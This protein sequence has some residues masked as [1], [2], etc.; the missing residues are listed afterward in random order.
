MS[1]AQNAKVRAPR[2]NVS[3]CIKATMMIKVA[4]AISTAPM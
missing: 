4:E 3:A 1:K 2:L